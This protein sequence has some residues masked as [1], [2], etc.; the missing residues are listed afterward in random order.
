MHL[1]AE[2]ERMGHTTG[3]ITSATGEKGRQA[4]PNITKLGWAVPIPWNGSI[5]RIAV[6]PTLARQTRAVLER[7][8]FDVIH[9]HE[10]LAPA[11]PI[12][13]LRV[14][15]GLN[16]VNV[17]TFHAFAPNK[18][19]SM[20]R[21]SYRTARVALRYYFNR[22]DGRIAVSPAAYQFISRYFPG[23]YRIIPNGVDLQRF[24]VLAEPLPQF[25]DGKLNILYLG[26]IEPRK[27]LKYLLR[28]I[29]HIRARYPQ[30]RFIIGSDGPRRAYYEERVR[31]Q[32]WPDVIFVGR[33]PD[34]ELPRYYASCDLFCAP[35]IGSES[36]G[37]VL[38]EAMASSK[39]VVASNIDGYR[40][41]IRHE[42]D[43][44]LVPPRSSEALA[45]AVC[46]LLSN[47]SLRQTMGA[48]GREHAGD[49]SWPRIA[50]RIS[51]YYHELIEQQAYSK[52]QQHNLFAL[53]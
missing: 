22:L 33:V 46:Q 41:V 52:S 39:P 51:D 37:V 20:P 38:L 7:E 3:I 8:Q 21:F 5:A 15:R 30:T 14:I 24:S 50:S 36:Q 23:E 1:A 9:L 26:R 18:I 17:G 6:S 2:L 12:T 53:L 48:S 4:E 32:G 34:A 27:G 25:A 19:M 31:Q 45:E 49:F 13:T 44:I 43:G 40:G 10:P 42:E 28:A 29:P 35:S 16:A 11:L 47:A